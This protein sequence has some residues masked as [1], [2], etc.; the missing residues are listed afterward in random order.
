MDLLDARLDDALRSAARAAELTTARGD[1]VGLGLARY[2]E[3]WIFT[4]RGDVPA[5]RAAADDA[6]GLSLGASS[7]L[8][9]TIAHC[10]Q[11]RV[12]LF[13]GDARGALAAAH[14]GEELAERAGQMGF[15]SH[16]L[17]VRGYAHLLRGEARAAHE[18][19]EG[20]VELDA[21]W[22]STKLHR[23]RGALELGDVRGAAELARGALDAPRGVRVRALAVLGFALGLGAGERA[24][25][26]ELLGEAVSESEALG[27]RPGL[28]E[29]QGFLAELCERR[30][31]RERAG[32]Y[33]ELSAELYERCGMRVHAEGVRAQSRSG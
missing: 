11:A 17:V 14:R 4:E 22:P 31:E 12:L 13:E 5:A 27:L 29:A 2:N 32:Y 10:A 26:E 20:L 19:F 30:G 15:R 33:A 8:L 7:T 6:L 1:P 25:A 24:E 9:D 18:C 3:C 16:A 28:A 21:R 23:A